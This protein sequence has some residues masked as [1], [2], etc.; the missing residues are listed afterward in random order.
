MAP[1]RRADWGY[2]LSLL[3]LIDFL[4]LCGIIIVIIML[5]FVALPYV[6][7]LVL[8]IGA[9]YLLKGWLTPRRL[10]RVW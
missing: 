6:I 4:L 1:Y 2:G 3:P 10:W 7:A 9:R 5:L 8:L